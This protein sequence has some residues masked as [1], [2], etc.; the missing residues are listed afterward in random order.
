MIRQQKSSFGLRAPKFL[1]IALNPEAVSLAEGL[2]AGIAVAL[3][4]LVGAV[5]H[6]PHFGLAALGALLTCFADPGGLVARRVPAVAFFAVAAGLAY[7]GFGLLRGQ[8]IWLAA[9]A[10]GLMIFGASYARVYGQAGLQV[11]NLLSV[12]T[13]LALDRP[14]PGFAAAAAQ[15][16]N[17][18]AGAAWA[19]VLTLAIWQVHPYAP[20]RRALAEIAG[21]L[22][23]LAKEL[24]A[25]ANAEESG[26]AYAAHAATH[27]RGVREAIE[28]ARGVTMV[29]FRRRGMMSRRAAQ[30]SIRLTALEQVFAALIALSEIL[31]NDPAARRGGAR[32]LRLI[33]G[34]LAALGP[35]I[36]ADRALDTPK[37]RRSL[38]RL[39][40][41]L[42]A[43]PADSALA[44]L[45][46]AA[47]ERLAVLI[48][49]AT[50][51]GE[52]LPGFARPL[53]LRQ[54]MLG[55]IWQ[56]FSLRS[57]PMRHALRAA[58][59]AAPVLAWT[60]GLHQ[61]FAHW[62]TITMVLCLQ[63]YFSAT[64][65]RAAERIAG[66][67]LGG[68]A[69]AAIG[70][71]AQTQ[72]ALALAMLPLTVFA[73][74]IRGVSYGAFTAALTPM[75]VLLVEQIAP[76]AD[77][78]RVAALR[79]AYTLLGGT[80]AVL[81]NLVLWPGF[82]G[83]RVEESIRAA[84]AAHAAYARAVF[85]ALLDGAPAPDAA[86]RAAGLAS[87]NLEA[88][89]SRALLEPH[90]GRDA[91]IERGAIVDAALRRIAGRLSV[92]ALDRPVLAPEALPVWREFADWLVRNLG[93]PP[94]PRP[95][96]PAG[97]ATETLIR[98]ARQVEL[99]AE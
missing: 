23:R 55:P 6:L 56:N 5:F 24:A 95:K 98:L 29:I 20:A 78:L 75:I 12:V 17:L 49:A 97:P 57:A 88:S 1:P 3:T 80:L 64:W 7:A 9:P 76:G 92:L 69:A 77:E 13:V 91:V 15:G 45:L 85:A 65:L 90:R 79:V 94:A 35:D 19:A 93:A 41:A 60:M 42:M 51:V 53:P 44:H 58:L 26:A 68:V 46:D 25:L 72:A 28:A 83:A 39:R 73:F 89:L 21:K 54:R 40:G 67:A 14:A 48:T 81:A 99:I 61:P 50:P 66:T 34:W 62:A 16:L 32:P 47:A 71:L 74:A 37:K 63:P 70:L 33:G 43:L 8:G 52:A 87:N 82:E 30:V 18:S 96:L 4:V 86:R 31:E 22:S 2:R 36:A 84:I 38:V 27:R 10:A 59:V 11:G